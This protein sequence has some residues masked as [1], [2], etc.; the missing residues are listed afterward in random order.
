MDKWMKVALEEAELARAEEEV[1]IGAVAVLDDECR[2]QFT[3]C[4][5]SVFT[6]DLTS[7]APNRVD[8]VPKQANAAAV[9]WR[10]PATKFC[11]R[12]DRIAIQL[13]D[14]RLLDLRLAIENGA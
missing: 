12:H 1:P 7:C 8:Q 11:R 10:R 13:V 9:G 6:G 5:P 4:P 2:G 3:F 14:V